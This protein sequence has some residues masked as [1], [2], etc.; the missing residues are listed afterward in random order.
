M[1]PSLCDPQVLLEILS[2]LPPVDENHDPQFL[3]RTRLEQRGVHCRSVKLA[4]ITRPCCKVH[5]FLPSPEM[6]VP[7]A[8]EDEDEELTFE[9]FLDT[10]ME[11]V[12]LGQAESIYTLA[13]SCLQDKKNQRPLS[14]QVW[15]G[16]THA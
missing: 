5:F 4:F 11:D 2:G 7:S 12:E 16:R 9:A 1:S 8:I 6:E 13:C 15:S 3:V 10:K 14:K